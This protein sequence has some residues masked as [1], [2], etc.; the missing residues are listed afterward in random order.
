[1]NTLKSPKSSFT[2]YYKRAEKRKTR[3]EEISERGN[4]LEEVKKSADFETSNFKLS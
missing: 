4:M 3:I 2:K 1:M